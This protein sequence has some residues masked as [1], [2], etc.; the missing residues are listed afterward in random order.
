[1]TDQTTPAFLFCVE[2]GRLESEAIML[3]ESLRTWGGSCAQ[4]PVYAFAPRPGFQPEPATLERLEALDVRL[5]D[6]PW[7]TASRTADLQ[8]GRRLGPGPS[9]S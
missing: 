1:L 6:E 7:S 5:I 3:V 4:A 8:Q 9:A 2:H